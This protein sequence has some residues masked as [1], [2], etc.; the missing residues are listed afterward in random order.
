MLNIINQCLHDISSF[1]FSLHKLTITLLNITLLFLLD[2]ESHTH[3]GGIS[4]S[5][6]WQGATPMCRVWKG[7]AP[8][9]PTAAESHKTG[10]IWKERKAISESRPRFLLFAPSSVNLTGDRLWACRAELPGQKTSVLIGHFSQFQTNK[11]ITAGKRS[12][13]CHCDCLFEFDS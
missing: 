5:E 10:I 3:S 11:W 13:W 4:V 2:P 9:W 7:R 6:M 1:S 8:L 12:G